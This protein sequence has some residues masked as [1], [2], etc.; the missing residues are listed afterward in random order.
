MALIFFDFDG[1]LVDSLENEAQYFVEACHRVGISQINNAADMAR[2][3]EGNFYE[4]CERRGIPQ[5][6]LSEALNIYSN[7]VDNPAYRV[8][9]FPEPVAALRETVKRFPVYIVSSNLTS[10]VELTLADNHISGVRQVIGYDIEPS[11][12]KKFTRI[13]NRYPNEKTYLIT[14][15]SG[16]IRE[17][18]TAGI[19]VIIG[20]TWGWHATE[21]VAA[22]E[23][24][25]LFQ[26][27]ADLSD[28]LRRLPAND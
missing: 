12:T 8:E 17:A 22:A 19:D 25:Y 5:A 21:T 28:F 4:E 7:K 26:Q 2:L 18:R 6:K 9:I 20:V 24:D 14:D 10:A 15:T 1:V 13:K 16:D 3:S 27:P 11:K 23:P